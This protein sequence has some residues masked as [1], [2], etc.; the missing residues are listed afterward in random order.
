LTRTSDGIAEELKGSSV[1]IEKSLQTLIEQNLESFLGV[2][3][4]AT[5]YI[6]DKE[7]RGRIDTLG[8]DV[9][10][11]PVIIEYKR[12]KDQNIVTQIH[13]YLN[14]L[15]RNKESFEQLVLN[16][17]GA[18]MAGSIEWTSPRLICIAGDF[19]KFDKLAVE[20]MKSDVA[21]IRYRL[22]GSDLLLLELV[23]VANGQSVQRSPIVLG[24]TQLRGGYTT[25]GRDRSAAHGG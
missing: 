18:D 1:V 22:Y 6:T 15:M 13:F 25:D 19:A 5:E 7:H 8:I 14:W 10:G 23:Y 21:L 16:Q 17:F 24:L 11:C 3:F 4:L 20:E 2:R 9:N 12:E